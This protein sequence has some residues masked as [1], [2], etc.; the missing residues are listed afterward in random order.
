[1]AE[2]LGVGISIASITIQIADS[3]SKVMNFCE[4]ICEAPTDVQKLIVELHLLSSI[5]L[6]IRDMVTTGLIPSGIETI[7]ERA[8]MLVGQDMASL[9]TL[10]SELE[11]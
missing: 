11:R 7:L 10:S 6:V 8:L 4:A 2:T 9:S 1:M 3:L 5:V